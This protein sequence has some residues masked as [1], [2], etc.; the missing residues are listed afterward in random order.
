MGK[1]IH[2]IRTVDDSTGEILHQQTNVI[3]LQKMPKEPDYIKL[4]VEDIGKLHGV[5][6]MAREVLLYVAAS[7]GYDGVASLTR[8]RRAS[9]ALTVGAKSV[10]V[11]NNCL[12]ECVKAGL[13]RLIERGEYEPNPALFGR[14]SWAEIRERRERFVA[15]FVYGPE[16]RQALEARRLTPDEALHFA[17]DEWQQRMGNG[18]ASNTH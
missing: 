1:M 14:G 3:E 17:P 13:L 5:T 4:Y 12:S 6:P 2:T 10:Q 8:R 16:G 7:M 9:I 11:V 18:C 15:S